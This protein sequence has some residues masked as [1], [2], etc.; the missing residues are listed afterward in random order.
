MPEEQDRALKFEE[1]FHESRKNG[2]NYLLAIG[3]DKYLHCPK[4]KN[5]VKDA[6][7]FI[8]LMTKRFQFKEEHV[9]GL[10]DAE[11]T[12][13]NMIN[14]F[15]DL[16]KKITS[17]DNLL[18]YF[19]GHGHYD[20]VFD[21]GHWIPVD[22]KLEEEDEYFSYNKL[23]TIIRAIKSHHTFLIVDSCYSG[24]V[25]VGGDRSSVSERLERDPSRWLFASGRNEVVSDG[26]PEGNSP[27]AEQLLSALERY[28]G[29]GISAS[30]L[31]NK[32]VTATSYNSKQTPIGRALQDVGDQGGEF[33]FRPKLD[34][35][36]DWKRAQKAHTVE[37]YRFFM[38][39]YPNGKQTEEAAWAIASLRNT[40]IAYDDYLAIYPSGKYAEIA[41]E[42]Q[43][44][45][46]EEDFWARC[47]KAHSISQYRSYLI[48]YPQGRYKQKAEQEI[49]I[50]KEYGDQE[51]EAWQHAQDGHTIE[52]YNFYLQNFP[53]GPHA[54][55]A[56]EEIRRIEDEQKAKR[57]RKRLADLEAKRRQEEDK[58][59]QKE[60]EERRRAEQKRKNEE[61]ARK[62]KE[63]EARKKAEQQKNTPSTQSNEQK[64]SGN[65]WTDLVSGFMEGYTEAQKRNNPPQTSQPQGLYSN[66]LNLAGNWRGNDGGMY[67]LT[68]QGN[69]VYF[70]GFNGYGVVMSQG[71]G[72]LNGY[73]LTLTVQYPNGV[74]ATAQLG[75]SANGRQMQGTVANLYGSTAI[76]LWR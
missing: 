28:S 13:K 9:S 11:A 52:T 69:N 23:I 27:F 50:M 72:V 42:K 49:Q 37:A 75:I 44:H 33:I 41:L 3:I 6:Q 73:Q 61:A 62:R 71:Q 66:Q 59:R 53:K 15:R 45:S 40:A 48:K 57:E 31:I 56:R 20:E 12:R 65:F 58:R 35:G 17:D 43:G 5:A 60:A 32:V 74:T 36:Y 38:T 34:E 2:K 46:E 51:R 64:G 4:L 30:S 39:T 16:A 10:F 19:S 67:Q 8:E 1:V 68:Q 22:A 76:S 21:E 55:I 26:S 54:G 63:E 18:V 29:E 7:A 70:R 47:K 24:S 25:F 14:L